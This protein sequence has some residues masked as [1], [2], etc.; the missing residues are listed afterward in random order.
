MP[1]FASME[2]P[3]LVCDLLKSFFRELKDSLLLCSLYEK[4]IEVAGERQPLLFL[5]ISFL[6]LSSHFLP[7]G[8]ESQSDRQIDT[9]R[10]LIKLALPEAHQR[11][12]ERLMLLLYQVCFFK[13]QTNKRDIL[14]FHHFS[15]GCTQFTT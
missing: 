3:N 4:W 1:N 2:D 7:T 15:Q 14:F 6:F 12:L 11:T 5:F 10:N 9:I 8:M 13:K